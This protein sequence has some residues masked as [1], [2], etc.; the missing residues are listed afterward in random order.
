[1]KGYKILI[2]DDLHPH[3]K[4]E[5]E[6]LG[7][8]VNSQPFFTRAETLAVITEY[9]GLAIRT[10]FRVDREV[11]D[12]APNLKFIARAGAGMDN[13]DEKYALN[14]GVVCLNAPE[15]N[16]DAV[17]EHALAPWLCSCR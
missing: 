4:E 6:K 11:L 8:E 5:A 14:K 7:Y 2:V 16:R 12:Q 9:H 1:M 3:F 10:K 15:G 13:I 17:A